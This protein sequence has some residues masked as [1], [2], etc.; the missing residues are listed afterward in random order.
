MTQT[1]ALI[2]DAWKHGVENLRDRSQHPADAEHHHDLRQEPRPN[3]PG[4]TETRTRN[5][6]ERRERGFSGADRIAAKLV[7]DD[8]L[9]DATDENQPQERIP[10]FSPQYR[11]G[12]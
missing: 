1:Q 8:D 9:D 7:L 2:G 6:V 11:G 12:D 5:T 3:N 4:D 10:V